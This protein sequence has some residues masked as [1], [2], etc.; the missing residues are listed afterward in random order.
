M[1][2]RAPA[3]ADIVLAMHGKAHV[4]CCSQAVADPALYIVLS[5]RLP[6]CTPSTSVLND[7][8]IVMRCVP[9]A[10]RLSACCPDKAYSVEH[11]T[12]GT[13]NHLVQY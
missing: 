4:I 3:S 7:A 8:S 2:V 1:E 12:S 13:S 11:E 5:R 10:D 6:T 9:L